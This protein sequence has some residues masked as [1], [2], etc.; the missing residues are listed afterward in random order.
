MRRECLYCT[1]V[2]LEYEVL[3]GRAGRVVEVAAS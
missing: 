1:A 3:S 2:C